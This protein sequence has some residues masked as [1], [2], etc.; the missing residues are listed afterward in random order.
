LLQRTFAHLLKKSADLVRP[1]TIGF[2]TAVAVMLVFCVLNWASLG[3]GGQERVARAFSRGVLTTENYLPGDTVRGVHQYNDCLIL[4]M[5]LDQRYSRTELTVS[6][7]NP[8]HTDNDACGDLR[9][10]KAYTHQNFYHNYVHGQTMLARYLLPVFGVEGMRSLYRSAISILLVAGIGLCMLRLAKGSLISMAFLL[11]MIGF[12]RFFGLESFG[13]SLSHAP[14]DFVIIAYVFWLTF[15]AG[16]MT[17]S[18]GVA[19]AAILGALTV[20][21]EFMTGG[22]PLG[23]AAVLGLMWFA[24]RS[25]N[26]RDC[27]AAAAAFTGAAAAVMAI[28]YA[29]VAI[30]FGGG[31]LLDIARLALF[32]VYGDLPPDRAGWSLFAAVTGSFYALAPGLERIAGPMLFLAIGFGSW[33]LYRDR[34]PE[35]VLLAGSNLPIFGWL[36]LF[37]QHTIVHAWFMDRILVW[38]MITGWLMFLLTL[39]AD[40]ELAAGR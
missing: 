19:A 1:V 27:L 38:T 8:F 25:P 30:V 32:R 3:R 14:S 28:H 10:G 22:L 36:I 7:S 23:L 34:R 13:Q 24:L 20:V 4:G 2:V 9:R 21:F 37:R 29:A 11:S 35:I 12:A 17:R 26:V 15:K 33:S 16:E 39:Q 18:E 5:A 6:P 40:R 31:E